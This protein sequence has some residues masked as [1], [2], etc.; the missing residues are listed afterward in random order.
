MTGS[1]PVGALAQILE[2]ARWAPSGDNTQP[3][4]FEVVSAHHLVVHGFDTRD[5]CV[6]DLD[7]RASQ[8][9][10]GALVE[11]VAIA[12]TAHGLRVDCRWR[13]DSPD[14]RP[15]FDLKF[16]ADGGLQR[17][18]LHDFIEQR[19]VQ[20]KPY[21]TAPLTADEKAALETS[22][23]GT[24]HRMLWLESRRE[25]FAM[26]RLLF[27]SARLRLVTPEAYIVH[28]DVIE[29]N[30]RHSVDRIPDQALGVNQMMLST[31]RFVMHSWE[32][33]Q[34]FNRFLAGTW[35]PRI[36][37]DF[38]PALACGAHFLILSPIQPDGLTAHVA[39]GRA[40]QRFWLTATRLGLM[41]QPE[42]T[43]LIFAR[44]AQEN[45]PFS[46]HR[47]ASSSARAVSTEWMQIVGADAASRGV[48]L[49][50]IGR[51]QAPLSRS[52]RHDVANLQHVADRTSDRT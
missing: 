47:E 39:A 48:F 1:A 8:M 38:V 45:R 20:R 24:G 28:R 43:P 51:A 16:T 23:S 3:W 32:R 21:A 37:M 41:L 19:S 50:R 9:S 22:V 17:D 2:M 34:F 15:T 30:A 44:Y 46:V 5:Y 42:L 36:Q 4:R 11:T 12:A 33:V 6:Y 40:L 35:M 26:A 52:L 31:M 27:R 25:R 49:G 18:P 7:G 29:W 14:D 13:S 10:L